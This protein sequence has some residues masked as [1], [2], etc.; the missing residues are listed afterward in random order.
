[1]TAD[2]QSYKLC[3]TDKVTAMPAD[4]TSFRA[5]GGRFVAIFINFMTRRAQVKAAMRLKTVRVR[6]N[7][8]RAWVNTVR[9][10]VNTVRVR[11]NTVRVHSF[12]HAFCLVFLMSTLLV[13]SRGR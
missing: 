6:V 1:M 13:Q 9:V 2:L 7:T 8:V 11:V 12:C 3:R 5:T 4:L 10:R